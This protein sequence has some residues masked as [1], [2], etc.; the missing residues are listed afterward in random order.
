MNSYFL[1]WFSF[2]T[3]EYHYEYL[4]DNKT[5]EEI[6][7]FIEYSNQIAALHKLSFRYYFIS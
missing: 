6:V 1:F 4:E 7:E 5:K 2:K 3:G